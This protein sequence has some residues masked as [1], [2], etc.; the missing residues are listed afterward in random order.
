MIMKKAEIIVELKNRGIK[1]PSKATKQ[2][3]EELMLANLELQTTELEESN[4]AKT[5]EV[6]T[7]EVKTTEDK[8]KK[9]ISRYEVSYMVKGRE[10]KVGT[11]RDIKVANR[12]LTR[13]GVSKQNRI[14]KPI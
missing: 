8:P 14:I 10:V 2:E 4:E 11:F 5:T 6:E 9:A 1:Y 13:K 3:L 12:L 7:V